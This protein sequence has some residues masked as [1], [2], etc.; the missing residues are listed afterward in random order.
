MAWRALL[1]LPICHRSMSVLSQS[2]IR[3]RL[4][5][6]LPADAF[7]LIR[8]NLEPVPLSQSEVIIQAHAPIEHVYFL[9]AGVTSVVTRTESG[10]RIEIGLVGR[11]GFAGVPVLLGADQTPHETFMQVGGSALRM[12]ADAF[13]HALEQSPALQKLL[14]R[15]VQVFHIQTAQTAACNGTH[16][17]GKRLARWLLMC[18]DRLDGDEL[19][20]THEFIA[21]MLAVRRPGVTEAL[22]MLEREEAIRAERRNIVVLDRRKLEETAGES[23][24]IPEAEYERLIGPLRSV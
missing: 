4:L 11:D 5:A 15:F 13:R 20:L 3:N 22:Q 24:G 1:R 17:V 10:R 6:A 8:P 19:P 12:R 9:E 2:P 23:Y 16:S 14:L 18:H 7:A 21:V